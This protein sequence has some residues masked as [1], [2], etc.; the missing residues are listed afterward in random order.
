MCHTFVIDEYCAACRLDC[1][2]QVSNSNS[3]HG[4]KI[5]RARSADDLLDNS[6]HDNDVDVT[7]PPPKPPLNLSAVTMR[8]LS[9]QRRLNQSASDGSS[10]T[11]LKL[12]ERHVE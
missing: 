1:R 11:I 4:I 10:G 7:S 5:N 9:T 8:L 3:C 12:G 6:Y 2:D